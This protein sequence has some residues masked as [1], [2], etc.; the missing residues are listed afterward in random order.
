MRRLPATLL[1]C[2]ALPAL[3][4]L[5][6][7][8]SGG[9][10]STSSGGTSSRTAASAPAGT[11]SLKVQTTPKFGAP[12]ASAPVLSGV[13]QIAYRD[14]AINPDTVK[15]RTG[16][17]IKWT[18]YDPVEHNVTSVGGAQTFK[19]ANFG[20]GASFEATLTRPGVI[21]YLCTIHPASMNGTIEVVP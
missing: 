8:G 5:A 7:C 2:L 1:A 14:I 6:G 16:S 20:E 15:V 3:A 10:S 4:A 18:N 17:T 9:S 19:S 11:G 13:V 12:P 21:H